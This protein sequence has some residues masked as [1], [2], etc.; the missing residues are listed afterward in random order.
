MCGKDGSLVK[1]RIEGAELD[2]CDDC[3]RFGKVISRPK[4]ILTKKIPE[5]HAAIPLPKRKELLET[6]VPDY[7]SKIKN[8]REKLG[9]TQEE[10][11]K[12]LS[13]RESIMQ[14]IESGHFTPSIEQARKLE[15]AL[16]IHLIENFEDGEVPIAGQ[17]KKGDGFTLGDFIKT[18]KAKQ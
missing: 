18:R 6:I 10:F 3:S 9:L 1:A 13:E 17:T 15:K 14:K 11:S 7:A 2:V 4:P 16:N 8:A 12:K 5:R